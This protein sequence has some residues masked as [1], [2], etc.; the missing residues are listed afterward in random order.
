MDLGTDAG[1]DPLTAVE[2][3]AGVMRTCAVLADGRVKCWGDVDGGLP[4][5]HEERSRRF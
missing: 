1:G 2:V 3:T 5:S 4:G